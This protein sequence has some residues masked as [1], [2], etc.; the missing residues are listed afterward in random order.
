MARAAVA[1]RSADVAQALLAPL[2]D[3]KLGSLERQRAASVLLG[4]TFPLSTAIVELELPSEPGEVEALGWAE[5]QAL[6]TGL[7][8]DQG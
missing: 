6:A 8:A 1:A 3:R 5:L 7:L 4:E 2:D